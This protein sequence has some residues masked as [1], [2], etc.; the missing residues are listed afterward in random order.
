MMIYAYGIC[1]HAVAATLLGRRGLG[2]ARLRAVERG[3]LAAIYTR[4][5]SLRPRPIPKLIVDHERVVEAIMASGAVLPLRF[6]TEFTNEEKLA[7]ALADRRDEFLRSLE[8]VRGKAEIGIR[9][10]PEHASC[11]HRTARSTGRDYLLARAREQRR[12]RAAVHA[13]HAELAALSRATFVRQPPR[14]PAVFVAAYLVDHERGAD[15]R[16]Q[17]IQLARRREGLQTSVTGP[18]PPYSFATQEHR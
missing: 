16:L 14:P 3:G 8:R 10:T 5:R 17:A 6:G 7:N 13:V 15:F 11:D 2:G 9:V 18:W 4:H 12:R 1:G